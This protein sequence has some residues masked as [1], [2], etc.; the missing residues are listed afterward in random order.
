MR[1]ALV[2]GSTLAVLILAAA[3]VAWLVIDTER[4]RERL[5]T[6]LGEAL[7]MEVRIGQPLQF[8]L[9]RGVSV[10]FEDIQASIEGEV[11]ARTQSARVRLALFSLLTG[12][13]RPVELHI[14]RPELSVERYGQGLFNIYTPDPNPA[15]LE[16]LFLRR[17]RVSDARVTWLDQPS[18]LNWEFEHCDLD[19]RNIAHAGGLPDRAA[20][21]LAAQGALKCRVVRQDRFSATGVSAQIQGDDGVFALDPISA[22]VF[23]GQAAG[24][25][26]L[27][28]ASNPPAFGLK[29]RLPEFELG[30]FLA[31]TEPEQAAS[32]T[33]DFELDLEAQGSGWQEIRSSAAGS[34]SLSAGE[35]VLEGFNLDEELDDY[36]ETQRFNLIDVGATLLGGPIGLAASRGYAFSGLLG[37]SGGSTTIDRMISEWS[38]E[39]GMAQARDVAFRTL[40]NRLALAGALD[41][42]NYRFDDLRVTIL[43]R[44]GCA[45]VKQRIT[46]P[47]SDPDI[48]QPNFLVA[49][50]GPLLDLVKRGVDSI[51][52]NDCQVFYTGSLAH[53]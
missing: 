30:S 6:A 52:D 7:G 19:L 38:V 27:D 40:E 25:M 36:A 9:L 37:D 29:A 42:G 8:S 34:I 47:F 49:V 4:I 32:G 17:V 26:E 48:E 41:F 2:I 35:L 1:T 15:A 46:G 39:N 31:M 33:M 23:D 18:A 11:V 21:T 12:R 16:A 20:E 50:A 28:F 44:D 53:P 24:R 10:E 45:I 22:T 14:E 51:T 3:L 43:D 13:I 5:A